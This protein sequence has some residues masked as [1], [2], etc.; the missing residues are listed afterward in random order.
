MVKQGQEILW[1]YLSP[2]FQSILRSRYNPSLGFERHSSIFYNKFLFVQRKSSWVLTIVMKTVLTNTTI[3]VKLH[4]FLI[5]MSPSLNSAC[6][7]TSLLQNIFT[8]YTTYSEPDSPE[9]KSNQGLYFCLLDVVST[10][11]QNH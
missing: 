1:P 6:F 7:K 9:H 5:P 2:L 11:C 4:H 10:G 3:L 8:E